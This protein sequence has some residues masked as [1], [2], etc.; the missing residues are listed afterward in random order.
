MTVGE[1]T[2]GHQHIALKRWP[3][4]TSD[5]RIGKYCSIAQ[6]VIVFLGGE[7]RPD[8]ITTY[9]FSAIRPQ[10][11]GI[12]GH[13][14]TKGDVIIGNDVWI[15]QG[16]VIMSGVTIGDG[17]VIGAYSVVRGAVGPYEIWRGNPARLLRRRF[18]PDAILE[19]LKMKWWDWPED[20]IIQH[21]PLL[22]QKD[23][24]GFIN[25]AQGARATE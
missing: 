17:A 1:H 12:K 6:D 2:Y 25:T 7:H 8:W 5:L 20:K 18:P 21:V 13:P 22:L 19:L 24:W 10:F 4:S 9:P 23:V 3:E 11:G 14:S 15:G 16:A